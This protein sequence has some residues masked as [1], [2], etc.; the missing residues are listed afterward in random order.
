[1]NGD[2]AEDL[3]V[4]SY[5]ESLGQASFAGSVNVIYGSAVGL[6]AAGSQFWTQDSPGVPSQAEVVERFGSAVA[7]GDFDGDGKFDL[8]IGVPGEE[9][10]GSNSAGA[11]NVLYGTAGGL[12]TNGT[13]FWTQASPGILEDPEPGDYWAG[14]LSA[15]DWGDDGKADLAASSIY[16]SYGSATYAGGVNVLYGAAS[17]LTVT[18]NQFWTQDSPGVR[19]Q[20]ETDDFFGYAVA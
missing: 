9:V 17:G 13:Q 3:S 1:L 16:E 15:G 11:I 10:G 18:G 5:G 4:G 8:A 2:G 12:A 20:A 14:A 6:K 7:A 19:D